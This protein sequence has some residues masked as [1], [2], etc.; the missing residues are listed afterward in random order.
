ML[1]STLVAGFD[2]I[3]LTAARIAS[4]QENERQISYR[5]KYPAESMIQSM[6][7]SFQKNAFFNNISYT[8]KRQMPPQ[9][10]DAS[11]SAVPEVLQQI[12]M[13]NYTRDMPEGLKEIIAAD[14]D[15]HKYLDA[16]YPGYKL[17]NL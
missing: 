15:L 4:Y 1:N 8:L 14:H 16:H 10:R 6:N 5:L 3:F 12:V 13:N 17:T 11:S 2:S 7:I 9:T